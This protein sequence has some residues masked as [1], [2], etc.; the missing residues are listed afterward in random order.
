MC[1][2][3]PYCAW[4]IDPCLI[5]EIRLLN[6]DLGFKT[7]SS[8][9]GHGKYEPTIIVRDEL[10]L[11]YELYSEIQLNAYD[12]RKKKQFNRYYKKDSEGIYYI[13]EVEK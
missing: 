13:P 7:I 2:K 1:K 9:C 4:K 8:C 11:C 3:L 12:R 5:E 6:Q 10:G